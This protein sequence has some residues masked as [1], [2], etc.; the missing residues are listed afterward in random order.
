MA[1]FSK[2]IEINPNYLKAYYNRGVMEFKLGQKEN[3]CVDWA[4]A[5]EL[6]YPQ[7]ERLIKKN[8]NKSIPAIN[9]IVG[10]E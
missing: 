8:C 7:A 9:E 3:A 1:D 10:I 2:A 5:G 6:G 4:K